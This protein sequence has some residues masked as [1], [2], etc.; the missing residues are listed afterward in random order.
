MRI[1]EHNGSDGADMWKAVAGV[2]GALA[3]VVAI[4]AWVSGE[5]SLAG[6]LHKLEQHDWLP[7]MPQTV[8]TPAV[9]EEVL[10]HVGS[11]PVGARPFFDTA[12]LLR[13]QTLDNGLVLSS[14]KL[15]VQETQNGGTGLF[16]HDIGEAS[17][18]EREGGIRAGTLRVYTLKGFGVRYATLDKALGGWKPL[19]LSDVWDLFRAERPPAT[20]LLTQRRTAF[21]VRDRSGDLMEGWIGWCDEKCPW[22]MA[23]GW[24]L[25]FVKYEPDGPGA[26]CH[27]CE[28]IISR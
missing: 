7:D 16:L 3:A 1:K 12:Q 18:P 9:D 6:L 8:G 2:L 4:I 10:G 23:R 26:A 22:S 20:G 24:H 11:L 13:P 21:L 17:L 19:Y 14:V 15:L 25:S 27:H 5:T 28:Q